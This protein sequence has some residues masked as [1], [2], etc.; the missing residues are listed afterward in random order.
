MDYSTI[1]RIEMLIHAAVMNEKSKLEQ[2]LC[3]IKYESEAQEFIE[4]LLQMQP[5]MGFHSIPHTVEEQGQAIRF[6]VDKDDYNDK[7]K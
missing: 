1:I 6:A 3:D 7:F 4:E 2:R 5:I